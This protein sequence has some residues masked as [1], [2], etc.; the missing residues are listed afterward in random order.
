MADKRYDNFAQWNEDMLK[1]FDL[2]HY[3]ANSNFAVRFIE[4]ARVK[5]ILKFIEAREG[6]EIIEIGCGAGDIIGRAERGNLTGV[7]ISPYILGVARR[8]YP[9]VKF[10]AGNAEELPAEIAQKRYDK[11]ICSEVIEHVENPD[12]VLAEIKRL[13]KKESVVVVSVPNEGLIDG[14]KKVLQM[15]GM[16]GRFF[17]KFSQKM[18]EEWHLHRFSLAKLKGIAQRDYVIQKVKRIPFWWLPLRYVAKMKIK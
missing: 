6:D 17:P 15:T 9:R 4:S 12:K 14:V 5:S 16:F 8:R 1:K 11:I 3:H 13:A 10:V 18:T 7:D 2:E